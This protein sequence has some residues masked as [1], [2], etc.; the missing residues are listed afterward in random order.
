M[1]EKTTNFTTRF[2]TAK[3]SD[4][5]TQKNTIYHRNGWKSQ[6][7]PSLSTWLMEH[8]W[9]KYCLI[10]SRQTKKTL[11]ASKILSQRLI[12]KV[13]RHQARAEQEH[14]PFSAGDSELNFRSSFMKSEPGP[15]DETI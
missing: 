15:D 8:N 13:S 3:I 1:K 5:V 7:K 6:Q 2:S 12:V 11:T 14:E 9:L 4:S 10:T